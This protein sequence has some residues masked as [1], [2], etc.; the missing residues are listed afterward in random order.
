MCLVCGALAGSC[1][2]LP[3]VN[4][5]LMG[6]RPAEACAGG[7]VHLGAVRCLSP[8]KLPASSISHLRSV[9]SGSATG[10]RVAADPGLGLKPRSVNPRGQIAWSRRSEEIWRDRLRSAADGCV[11]LGVFRSRDFRISMWTRTQCRQSSIAQSPRT[12]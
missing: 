12:I 1:R 11:G 8:E 10:A 5:T 6:I 9:V 4:R 3:A 7:L 2:L